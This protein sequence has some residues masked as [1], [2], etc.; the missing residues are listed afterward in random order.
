MRL[1]KRLLALAAATFVGAMLVSFLQVL[2]N[3]G[4]GRGDLKAFSI[5][6]LIAAILSTV[7]GVS[8]GFFHRRIPK[9]LSYILAAAIGGGVAFGL[10][11]GMAR[12]LGPW[13][14]AW[15]FSPFLSL[16]VGCVF[17]QIVHV[18]T[19]DP[20]AALRHAALPAVGAFTFILLLGFAWFVYS[21]PCESVRMCTGLYERT[22]DA[23]TIE[24]GPNE[25]P[26]EFE[27]VRETVKHGKI[28]FRGCSGSSR[29]PSWIG[30][31]RRGRKMLFLP[32]G[33]IMDHTVFPAAEPGSPVIFLQEPGGW[34]AFPASPAKTEQE[35]SLTPSVQ[36]IR[37]VSST[38]R[39]YEASFN[40]TMA[41]YG[42]SC[43]LGFSWDS[44]I[45]KQR[46]ISTSYSGRFMRSEV[47]L[48]DAQ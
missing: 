16:V 3:S 34:T 44:S 14:G 8:L 11:V 23:L 20:A 12:M 32:S 6:S 26:A 17:G 48:V 25:L 5:W 15:S 24:T 27:F 9:A 10:F 28:A 41:C 1:L 40:R 42:G 47:R 2:L 7:A 43:S 22:S 39:E 46:F 38:E 21:A 30:F 4:F 45:P 29:G 35:V 18:L 36:W 19:S 13:M 37:N 31:F 33:P